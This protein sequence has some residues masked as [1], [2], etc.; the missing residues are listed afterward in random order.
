MVQSFGHVAFPN[1]LI[2]LQITSVVF[3]FHF[4]DDLLHFLGLPRELLFVQFRLPS[5]EFV[6][7]LPIA[8]SETVP[9]RCKLSKIEVKAGRLL[10][11]V[12]DTQGR[13]THYR[14]CMV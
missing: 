6:I 2:L 3:A 5:E 4:L 1:L 13:D 8:A 10:A 7:G 9:Y 12:L 14:W 11:T